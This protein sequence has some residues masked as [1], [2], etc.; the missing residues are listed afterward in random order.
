MTGHTA[1]VF[2]SESRVEIRFSYGKDLHIIFICN[3][4]YLNKPLCLREKTQASPFSSLL[5]SNSSPSTGILFCGGSLST[6]ATQVNSGQKQFTVK[7][8]RSKFQ[9]SAND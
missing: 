2:A 4:I 5:A 6:N 3:L 1:S 7:L 9:L 8:T